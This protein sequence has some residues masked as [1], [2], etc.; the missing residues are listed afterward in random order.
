MRVVFWLLILAALPMAGFAEARR[1]SH[2]AD[3]GRNI[4]ALLVSDIHFDPLH[5]PGKIKQL[6]DAPVSQW[7]SILSAAPSSNQPQAFAQLQQTCRARGVDTSYDLLRSSLQAMR[8][9]LPDA[10]FMTVSGDLVAHSFVCRYQT[11]LPQ[12]THADYQTFVLKTLS[13]VMQELR[14]AYPAIPIYVA[15][16]NNDTACGDYRLDPGSEFLLR[17]GRIFAEG[18]PRLQRQ[19]ELKMFAT[20]GYYSVTM[21]APMRDTRLIVVNDIFL[22]PNSST[23][24]GKPDPAAI[25]AQMA[26]LQAQLAEARRLRQRVWVMGHIPPGIDPY[27]TVAGMKNICTGAAPA[28]FLSSDKLAELL[29]ANAGV[30]RLGIFAHTHMDEVR[31]LQPMDS[32][33]QASSGHGSAEKSS[34]GV[35]LKLVP[36]IS[37]VDGN[38]PSFLAARIHP[39]T[40]MLQDYRV[41]A[42]SNHTGVGTTWSQEYDFAEAYH[43]AEFSPETVEKMIAEFRGDREAKTAASQ[44]Y[45]R[46]YF[47]GNLSFILKPFWPLYVCSLE[48]YTAKAFTACVCSGK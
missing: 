22:S 29:A 14:A 19:Q 38:N 48:N 35:V 4:P 36:S 25:A 24:A 11:L 46:D 8:A 45:I 6:V 31:L 16:G 21:A 43:Q 34:G 23:C 1:A 40:A 42:A 30:I 10:Q 33:P 2:V 17:A 15:M 41:I 47:V 37:P 39:A 20:G 3:G 7:N 28:L 9:Q 44:Q 27:A 32:G 18:L 5:D 12:S 26:W 13:F